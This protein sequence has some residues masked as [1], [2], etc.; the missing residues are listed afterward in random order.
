MNTNIRRGVV[1]IG[2]FI[3]LLLLFGVILYQNYSRINSNLTKMVMSR[4]LAISRMLEQ[5][6]AARLNA[7]V[8]L[9]NSISSNPKV[10][11]AILA[12]K[13]ESA[14]TEV[15]ELAKI[16]VYEDPFITRIVLLDAA[17]ISQKDEPALEGQLGKN[18][19][20]FPWFK[21]IAAGENIVVSGVYK[22]SA[23]PQINII[24][25]ASAVRDKGELLKGVVVLQ[26]P[27]ERFLGL[28]DKVELGQGGFA[29]ITDDL[30]HVVAHPNHD[31]NAE[32]VDFSGV[33]SVQSALRGESGVQE[34]YNQ[35]DGEMRVAA[36]GQVPE[37]KWTVVV[38]EPSQSAFAERDSILSQFIYIFIG[39]VILSGAIAALAYYYLGQRNIKTPESITQKGFTLIE[40]L[41]V[42]AIVAVL[43][44]V[45]ILTLNPAELIKQARDSNRLSDLSTLRSALSLYMTDVVSPNLAS[46]SVGYAGCYLSTTQGN[47]TTS[48]KCGVFSGTGITTVVSTTAANYTK[49]DSTGWLPVKFDSL[50]IGSPIG[51]LP[52]DPLNNSAYFYAYAA[53]STTMTFELDAFLES[54]KYRSTYPVT[55]GGNR[56]DVYEIGSAPGLSL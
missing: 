35:V 27:A 38:V 48:A 42:I 4:R 23:V 6:V 1:A 10:S 5:S 20:E 53:S 13:W 52:I 14:I 29:Y 9:A 37:Y 2:L 28:L 21:K 47:G 12:G 39:I 32:I 55:D 54:N 31:V 25:V 24:S 16:P 56:S 3:G 17:G 8:S 45:V 40:L 7:I 34:A 41:V 36:Y 46:S 26:I 33:A 30:G 44:V 50:T 51:S 15:R 19:S 22:R 18:S 49:V 11:S 43:A